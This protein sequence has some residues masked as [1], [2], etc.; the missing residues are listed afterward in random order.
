MMA[1]AVRPVLEPQENVA[2]L[3]SGMEL[4]PA[5]EVTERLCV[6]GKSAICGLDLC[7]CQSS[8]CWYHW[9]PRGG[10]ED[11]PPAKKTIVARRLSVVV[12][13]QQLR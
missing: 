11:H 6:D 10:K 7:G 13:G 12:R 8:M 4:P 5:V 9:S 1:L 2:W 3:D